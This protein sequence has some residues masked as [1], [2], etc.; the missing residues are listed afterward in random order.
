[1]IEGKADLMDACRQRQMKVAERAENL[2]ESRVKASGNLDGMVVRIDA[3]CISGMP[4][5]SRGVISFHGNLTQ[6]LAVLNRTW[7]TLPEQREVLSPG[8]QSWP[9][10]L[11]KS[12]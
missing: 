1:M 7:P 8:R 5:E 12:R 11:R 6:L 9:D 3:D 4:G 10:E 2:L